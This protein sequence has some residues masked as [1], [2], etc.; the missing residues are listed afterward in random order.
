MLHICRLIYYKFHKKL[1]KKTIKRLSFKEFSDETSLHLLETAWFLNFSFFKFKWHCNKNEPD[2][3]LPGQYLQREKNFELVL[4]LISFE[5]LRHVYSGGRL[6]LFDFIP[7][8]LAVAPTLID[9]IVDNN[10]LHLR[11]HLV[12]AVHNK[13]YSWDSTTNTTA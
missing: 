10:D 2:S 5:L 3:D 1:V 11:F 13:L 6:F 8:I 7:C 9:P 4:S 12:E